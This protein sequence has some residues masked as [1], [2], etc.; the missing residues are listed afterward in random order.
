MCVCV[1][2]FL[3][4]PLSLSFHYAL[5]NHTPCTHRG[6]KC[7]VTWSWI[8]WGTYAFVCLFSLLIYKQVNVFLKNNKNREYADKIACFL[9]SVSDPR[10]GIRA[11]LRAGQMAQW[12]EH[13]PPKTWAQ[14]PWIPQDGRREPAPESCPLTSTHKTWHMLPHTQTIIMK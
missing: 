14:T 13:R 10:Q 2:A 9:P 11:V 6:P 5:D 12:A 4:L 1:L 7:G 3:P 8:L